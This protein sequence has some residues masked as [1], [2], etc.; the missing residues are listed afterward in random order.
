MDFD[1]YGGYKKMSYEQCQ[2]ANC[3]PEKVMKK[4]RD[5]YLQSLKKKCILKKKIIMN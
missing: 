4:E 5:P 1:R 3:I 2:D